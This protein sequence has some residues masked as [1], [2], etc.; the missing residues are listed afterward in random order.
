MGADDSGPRIRGS[1]VVVGAYGLRTQTA[2][3][4]SP[5]ISTREVIV[6]VDWPQTTREVIVGMDHILF[7]LHFE[8]CVD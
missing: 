8:N 1:K 2:D 6:G 5:R 4:C 3:W 7:S